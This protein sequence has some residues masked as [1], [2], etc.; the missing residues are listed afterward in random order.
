MQLTFEP[1]TAGGPC[2]AVRAQLRAD[3]ADLSFPLPT[4][5]A[6]GESWTD[7][8]SSEACVSG[9]AGIA[10]TRRQFVVVDDTTFGSVEAVIVRRRDSVSLSSE[11]TLGQHAI[12]LAA[13]GLGTARIYISIPEGRVLR[14]ERELLLKIDVTSSSRTRSFVQ[15]A[16]SV[17]ELI[18]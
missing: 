9:I 2:S 15:S 1:A 16:T 10:Q 13:R 14:L 6:R 8:I 7:S 18:R 3:L 4:T 11:G 5:I 12:T 17:A